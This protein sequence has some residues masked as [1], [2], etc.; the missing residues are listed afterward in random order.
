MK[1]YNEAIKKYRNL[2]LPLKVSAWF[3]VCTAIQRGISFIS[4][5]IFTR[6]LTTADYGKVSVYNSW[7][8]I[9]GIFS[10]FSLSTS[11]SNVGLTEFDNKDD[12][13][14]SLVELG[15]LFSVAWFVLV[16]LLYDVVEK[17][18]GIEKPFLIMMLVEIF[19]SE[20][21]SMWSLRERYEYRYKRMALA[22]LLASF[23]SIVNSLFLIYSGMQGY[24]GRIIGTA[25]AY[26]LVGMVCLWAILI[27]SKRKIRIEYWKFAISYNL[28]MIPHIL[29][30][31]LLGQMDRI[32]IKNY[33]GDEKAGIY[34]AAYSCALIVQLLNTSF[35]ASYNPWLLQKIKK[36]D[37][38]GI[39][40]TSNIVFLVYS[41]ILVSLILFS[42]EVLKI[43]TTK[44]YYEGMYAIPPVACSMFFALIFNT[45]APVEYS[46][47]NTKFIAVAST[48]AALLNYILNAIFIP[49]YG[50]VSAA[51][52]TLVC[53]MIYAI[54]HYIYMSFLCKRLLKVNCLFDTRF[55]LILSVFVLITALVGN[56][57]YTNDILRYILIVAIAII[58]FFI[59]QKH[60]D[61]LV[62]FAR[63]Q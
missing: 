2:S 26:A 37:Y 10:V 39:D 12:F 29:S 58:L 34:S 44:D 62:G 42:P 63:K 45:V 41:T 60:K 13:Q 24:Y 8:E 32:M 23:F 40:R 51:Y 19:F 57:V 52:T 61:M 33:C 21:I 4:T 9:I 50:Y 3:F 5:P 47:K 7:R 17:Y 35:S 27:R 16:L 38:N 25:S 49:R 18:I 6:L 56:F 15:L 30:T 36:K 54:A 1:L 43:M 55:I 48:T 46:S 31:I 14:F 11:V 59:L 20:V 28:P 53:Y 22:T